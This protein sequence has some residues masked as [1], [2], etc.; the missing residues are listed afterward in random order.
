MTRFLL[1]LASNSLLPGLGAVFNLVSYSIVFTTLEGAKAMICP[2]GGHMA[3]EIADFQVDVPA[4]MSVWEE[5]SRH[6]PGLL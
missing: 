6:F 2:L 3:I 1:F 4:D 5:F